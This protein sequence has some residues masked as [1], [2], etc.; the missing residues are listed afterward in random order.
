M[1]SF[2]TSAPRAG[3]ETHQSWVFRDTLGFEVPIN[4]VIG[5]AGFKDI[6]EGGGSLGKKGS[7]AIYQSEKCI[8]RNGASAYLPSE[9]C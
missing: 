9:E 1:T 3:R 6:K 2:S 8:W 7:S 5:E 4:T